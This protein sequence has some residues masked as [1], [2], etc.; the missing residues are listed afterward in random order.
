M[1]STGQ[2]RAA[3]AL[4]PDRAERAPV[5]AW[6]HTYDR[7][8]SAA[9][10][11]STTVGIARRCGLD[12]VKLQIR[13]TCFAEA[14]GARWRFSGSATAGPV[15]EHAGGL[16]AGAWQRIADWEPN[17]G[18]LREQVEA[19]AAVVKELGPETPCIQ[20]VFSPGM[21]GWFL[22]GRDHALLLGLLRDDPEVV[23]AGLRRIAET[24]AWFSRESIAA[25]A[26]GVFYAINPLADVAMVPPEDYERML[27]PHDRTALAGAEAGWFNMLHLCGP[28]VNTR[29]I[30]ALRPHAVNWS[31]H[32]EA[33][34]GLAE[35][36]DSHRVAVAG[37]LHRDH[38]IRTGAPEEVRRAAADALGLTGGRGHLLTPG[39]P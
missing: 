12:F 30:E 27:L 5:S 11:A 2:E 4:R 19:L 13:A 28:R 39:G 9:E 16:D 15:V 20:T 29:L 32:D 8:W 14:F 7:E 25:G 10:L 1:N 37:G 31:V 35:V 18:V 22:A 33:N 24:L 36:R 6:G 26:A 17:P 3:A 21:V 34:P 38:P 23:S